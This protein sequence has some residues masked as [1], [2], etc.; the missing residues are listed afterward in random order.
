[1]IVFWVLLTIHVMV[2]VCLTI[3]VLLQSGKGGGLAGA[4]GGAGASQTFFGG[5]GAGNVLTKA[6]Q[7]LA[8][9]FMLTSLTL[10]LLGGQRR[11]GP[12]LFEQTQD[13]IEQRRQQAAGVAPATAFEA[14]GEPAPFGAEGTTPPAS[15]SAPDETP[16]PAGAEPAPAGTQGGTP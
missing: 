6:T 14:L 13:R 2:S 10:V 5:R 11:S 9:A 12:G 16:A 3:V 15:G 4:F 7:I 8:A 1:M